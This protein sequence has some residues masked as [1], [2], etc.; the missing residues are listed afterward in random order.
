MSPPG[1][2][3]GL[4]T[5]ESVVNASREPSSSSSAASPSG[6]SSGLRELLEEEA[7]DE[8]ARRLAAGAVRERDELVAELRPPR[9]HAGTASRRCARRP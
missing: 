8:R 3:S 2:K 1:K 7:L 5:Y 9:P 4:T 6:S